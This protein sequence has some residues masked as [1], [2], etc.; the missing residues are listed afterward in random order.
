MS[1]ISKSILIKK[2]F[3]LLS[4][5][6]FSIF[7]YFLQSASVLA[8][9][10]ACP[11]PPPG[12]VIAVVNNDSN[13]CPVNTCYKPLT[14]AGSVRFECYGTPDSSKKITFGP[15]WFYGKTLEEGV[16][17][18]NIHTSTGQ[19]FTLD[20]SNQYLC[21]R[22]G[23]STQ[24]PCIGAY[25]IPTASD[26]NTTIQITGVHWLVNG[27]EDTSSGKFVFS[28][29]S[30]VVN[31][32]GIPTA[33]L[34]PD[35]ATGVINYAWSDNFSK[36]TL[37]ISSPTISVD[38]SESVK[39][40]FNTPKSSQYTITVSKAISNSGQSTIMGT[41]VVDC[42]PGNTGPCS[43]S[44]FP[45]LQRILAIENFNISSDN[46]LTFDILGSSLDPIITG[47]STYTI[48]VTFAGQD[49]NLPKI[50]ETFT[51][52]P[53]TLNNLNIQLDPNQLLESETPSK[54]INVKILNAPTIS[55]LVYLDEQN[56]I[57]KQCGLDI[58]LVGG[59]CTIPLILPSS[60]LSAGSSG[61]TQYF[62]TVD[63]S[64]LT[65]KATLGGSATFTVIRD[66]STQNQAGV[67]TPLPQDIENCQD[68]ASK[69]YT[70]TN[71]TAPTCT[72]EGQADNS[73]FK[74]DK[75][76]DALCS[77]GTAIKC[78]AKTSCNPGELV[79]R[80]G[81]K[82]C[83]DDPN[84]CCLQA[85]S[86]G[87][88]LTDIK[89]SCDQGVTG[90][91]SKSGA[92]PCETPNDKAGEK[93]GIQTALGCLPTKPNEM[94]QAFITF[95]TFA[96]GGIALLIMVIASIGMITSLGNPEKLKNAQEQFAAAVIGLLFI[97]FS[98]LLLKIIGVDI[99][100]LKGFG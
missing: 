16:L 10:A 76:T 93:S 43:R 91:V 12:Q 77:E 21:T 5:V 39:V 88:Q 50:Q 74:C 55:F 98:V 6:L 72:P 18:V 34:Q 32:D 85:E 71:T 95:A 19:S 56:Q 22:S 65:T 86:G 3:R 23:L 54:I 7:L 28:S 26:G 73:G 90:P 4:L 61:S 64:T 78:A 1:W 48:E 17:I 41:I 52:K 31:K 13:N 68:I 83:S 87:G 66:Q 92:L 81:F 44:P 69:G 15:I 96:G 53:N 35:S 25:S 46:I 47:S 99:L 100:G 38:Q 11:N 51:V 14:G 59:N 60:G 62:I 2:I 58:P 70:T 20:S 33:I 79:C 36:P 80:T 49:L 37:L 67:C 40:V 45:L 29:G 89:I 9:T 57:R 94:V 8:A 63:N 97:I 24:V 75:K 30:N 42:A 84:K 82:E 27:Q